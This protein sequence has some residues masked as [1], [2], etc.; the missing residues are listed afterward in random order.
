MAD[1][2]F[3]NK[4]QE[5]GLDSELVFTG[6]NWDTFGQRL[7]AMEE[8]EGKDEKKDVPDEL[9]KAL[10]EKYEGTFDNIAK[11]SDEGHK[12]VNAKW[13][14]VEEELG[15]MTR[16]A[17]SDDDERDYL[18]DKK[19]QPGDADEMDWC[20]ECEEISLINGE[21]E[22]CGHGQ[23]TEAYSEMK[24]KAS[25][26]VFTNPAQL[27]AEAVE[28]AVA[29]GNV[30]LANTILAARHERRLRLAG[31]I[32]NNI[33]T[34]QAHNLK[35]AKRRAYREG[36]VKTAAS[37]TKKTVKT[38]RS[39]DSFTKASQLANGAKKAFA[40]KAIAS[41]FPAEYVEAMLNTPVTEK[42]VV[43]EIKQVM[44]S[45]LTK[46]VKKTVVANMIKE[47]ELD[48]ANINRCKDYWKNELGYGDP[49]WVDELF[50]NS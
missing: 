6:I 19:P 17:D 41:G 35:L 22:Q 34:A 16:K 48:S 23:D 32:E 9:M 3:P 12:P 27:S 1:R 47:S 13:A 49:E 7:A 43:V 36:L 10:H 40:A 39:N 45:N 15:A 26:I 33:K 18:E 5:S 30:R 29:K 20:P 11:G 14:S 28:A 46:N 8:G 24:K 21:C 37:T 2:I 42:P 31:K 44:A 50:K 4:Y 25:K 38:A